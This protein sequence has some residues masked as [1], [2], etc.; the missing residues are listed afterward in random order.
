MD[1][2]Y[3]SSPVASQKL[4][5]VSPTTLSDKFF[6][7]NASIDDWVEELPSNSMNVGK[8]YSIRGPQDFS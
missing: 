2:T 5:D 7:F 1:Y 6:S 4:V 3:W 8:G